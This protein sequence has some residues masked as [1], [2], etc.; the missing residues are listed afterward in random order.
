M[1]TDVGSDHVG[2]EDL[3]CGPAPRV[4]VLQHF[5][6]AIRCALVSQSGLTVVALQIAQN[7]QFV[8]AA[9]EKV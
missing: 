8:G 2:V 3:D 5:F 6:V 4:Q 9:I 1:V 7:G